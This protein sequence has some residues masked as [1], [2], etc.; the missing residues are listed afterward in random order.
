[1]GGTGRAYY[2]F[3]DRR[4]AWEEG[5]VEVVLLEFVEERRTPRGAWVVPLRDSWLGRHFVLDHARK[6]Y[7]HPT[8][9]EALRAFVA[10]KEAQVAIL[11]A[12]LAAARKAERIGCTLLLQQGIDADAQQ[13][14]EGRRDVH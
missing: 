5:R 3:E 12:R 9:E 14:A 4:D 2:R 10:R 11:G 8:R 6:R 1:M 7:A 13:K